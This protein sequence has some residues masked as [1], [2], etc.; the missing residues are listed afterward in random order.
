MNAARTPL[1]IAFVD[2]QNLFHAA[3]V[4]FGHSYPNYDVKELAETVSRRMGWSLV[5]VRFYTGVPDASDN[6]FWNHF[7]NAK[8]PQMGREGIWTFQRP[9]RYRNQS[10]EV[11]GH[12]TVTRMVGSEKG[13]DIRIA[14]DVVSLARR[15]A[16]DVALVFSQDQDLSEVA[17]EIRE[18]ARQQGRWIKMASAFPA[19]PVYGNR[20][21]INGTD[22]IRID[23]AEYD[24]CLDRRD[25]RPKRR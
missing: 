12:G 11:P 20:R 17:D 16:L 21:G 6:A 7:W 13:I 1:A 8:L 15:Q 18:I 2:G 24:A 10:I 19:S 3:R 22:W 9:L 23:R 25:Y 14:L 4:A 5:Q